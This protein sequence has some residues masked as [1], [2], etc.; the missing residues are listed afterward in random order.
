[1]GKKFIKTFILILLLLDSL[2]VKGQVDTIFWFAAPDVDEDYA[3]APIYLRI[4]SLDTSCTVYITLPANPLI[5]YTI[6]LSANSTHSID[7]TMIKGFLETKA[8]TISN[9][10]LKIASTSKISVYYDVVGISEE[11]IV[12][13]EIFVLKGKYALGQKFYT[14]IQN[15]LSNATDENGYSGFDIVATQN[16]T[17]VTIVPTTEL[18]GNHASGIPFDIKLNMG[19]TYS[20]RALLKESYGHP[21]GSLITSTKPIAVT[22]KDDDLQWP[23]GGCRDLTGDQIVPVDFIGIEYIVIRGYLDGSERAVIFGTEENTEVYVKGV[24]YNTIGPGDILPISIDEDA[25]YI[26]TSKP[27]YLMHISGFGCQ[28][29]AP[30]L[31][32]IECSGYEQISFTRTTPNSFFLNIMTKTGNEDGFTLNGNADLVS[33]TDFSVVPNKPDWVYA[34]LEFTES[35]ISVST[36][37]ILKNSKGNFQLGLINASPDFR[38]TNYGYF[39]GFNQFNP[40]INVKDTCLKSNTS[41]SLTDE[42]LHSLVWNFGDPATGALN[43]SKIYRPNHVF[44]APGTYTVTAD[45]K[46]ACG[47]KTVKRKVTI[48]PDITLNLPDSVKTCGEEVLLDPETANCNNC[49]F[50]WSNNATTSTIKVLQTGNYQVKA[51]NS[52]GCSKTDQ[53]IVY[54]PIETWNPQKSYELCKNDSLI[55]DALLPLC[56]WSTGETTQK[57]SVKSAGTYWVVAENKGCKN[58]ATIEIKERALPQFSLEDSLIFCSDTG[59]IISVKNP[60][61]STYKYLWSNGANT[62]ATNVTSSGIYGVEVKDNFNCKSTDMVKVIIYNLPI[63]SLNQ[64]VIICANDSV[65]LYNLLGKGPISWSTGQVADTIFVKKP[66]TYIARVRDKHCSNSDTIIVTNWPEPTEEFKF[67]KNFCS[68]Q[69]LELNIGHTCYLWSTGETSQTI[70]VSTAGNY[71][72]IAENQGCKDTATIDVKELALP[73]FSLEDSLVFCSNNG[74][75]ISVKD[76]A[77]STYT[78]LWSNGATSQ[79][80][81]VPSSG[82]YGVEVK[83]DFNCKT[84]DSVKVVIYKLP[85]ISLNQDV[86]ICAEDSVKLYDLSGEGQI[87]WS[88]G[89]V[90]DVIYVKKPGTYTATVNDLHCYNS[91]SIVVANWPKPTVGFNYEEFFCKGQILELDAGVHPSYLWSTK[92]TTPKISVTIPGNYFVDIVDE[93]KCKTR[94]SIAVYQWELPKIIKIDTLPQ[95]YIKINAVDGSAPY[96]YSINSQDYQEDQSFYPVDPGNYLVTVKDAN[97][98]FISQSLSV[99]EDGIIIPQYF[100]PNDDGINDFWVITGLESYPETVVKIMDRFGKLIITYK[101]SDIPWDG[102]YQNKQMPADDYWYII[103]LKNRRKPFTGHVTI[104]R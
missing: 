52:A 71:W 24:L 74:A 4:S 104:V 75:T 42:N 49:K 101:G 18:F 89:Q 10:G 5:F 11:N 20:A 86:I 69:V 59:A 19:Q 61:L 60:A 44:S 70:K 34:Q 50:L 57:I 27:V 25:T 17:I 96:T 72:V 76:P 98:C 51:T 41:F 43:T 6:S 21:G 37:N 63:I 46:Y 31:P 66:G 38:S 56:Q 102:T 93:H 62:Q 13:S 100:S 65:K 73:Q 91:D 64:D 85:K 23:S 22:V 48:P 47:T 55:L 35:E 28:L 16:N 92:E 87:T 82:I 99:Y 1:M 84:K 83:D 53:V 26:N 40:S 88:T 2:I 45:M 8:N 80:T 12:N 39:S 78:Y 29:G 79:S 94:D 32:S 30:I 68:G 54:N 97:G 14:P 67:E 90:A 33:A 9:N 15:F 7:L 103:D 95:N 81:N 58:K 3:D 36:G 77:F